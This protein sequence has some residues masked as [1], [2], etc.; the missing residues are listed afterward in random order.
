MTPD[1]SIVRTPPWRDFAW[2]HPEWW[3][4]AVSAVC[5]I[6]ILLSNQPSGGEHAHHAHGAASV[7][8]RSAAAHWAA[9]V[10]AM[11]FPFLAGHL[12]SV[13]AR[14][15]WGRRHWA[16]ALF[17]IS[18]TALWMPFGLAIAP[19]QQAWPGV[20]WIPACLLVAAIWQLTPWKR[21]ALVACHRTA[22]LAPIGLRADLDCLRYGGSVF[23]NCWLSCWALML[24]CAVT[25][26][27]IAAM[28]VLTLLSWVEKAGPVD[29]R[30]QVSAALFVAA[31]AAAAYTR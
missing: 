14:S 6:F 11:M 4:L 24:V 10:A 21:A 28:P 29:R 3:A 16:M 18:Y 15:L 27:W 8:L 7:S 1:A 26:R 25:H 20:P 13:A 31:I 5:W 19:A 12:R 17:L 22:P 2:R 30:R 9:M 23:V